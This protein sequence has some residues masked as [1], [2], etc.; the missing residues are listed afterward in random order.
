[1]VLTL[2]AVIG[3]N[4][5]M[6][7]AENITEQRQALDTLSNAKT[8]DDDVAGERPGNGQSPLYATFHKLV[9]AKKPLPTATLMSMQK[10][11]TAAGRLY[12]AALIR[13]LD[14]PAG[15]VALRKLF[16][17]KTKVTYVSGCEATDYSV[18][19]IAKQ[20]LE[21]GAFQNFRLRYR[22]KS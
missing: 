15:I 21:N 11:S 1:M 22:C 7:A 19:E 2:V 9:V 20:L 17:D 5:G 13:E 18:G 8:F 4:V 12:I 3:S 16:N 6:N 10:R 14:S